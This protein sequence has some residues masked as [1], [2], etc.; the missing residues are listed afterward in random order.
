MTMQVKPGAST[1]KMPISPFAKSS[2][3]VLSSETRPP[4]RDPLAHY[5]KADLHLAERRLLLLL[6]YHSEPIDTFGF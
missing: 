5:S 2:A 4:Q 6:D 1:M 3:K